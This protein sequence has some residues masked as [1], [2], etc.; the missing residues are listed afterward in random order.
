M[1]I[2]GGAGSIDAEPLKRIRPLVETALR[3]FQGT[4]ISGGTAVGVPGCVGDVA[5]GL[6]AR[7]AKGFQLIGYLPH[8]LPKDAPPDSRYELKECG[9]NGFT[10]EQILQSWRDLTAQGVRPSEVLCLGFGGGPLC[11]VE[12]CV[13]LALGAIVA[14][15]PA[16]EGDAADQLLKDPLWADS[17]NLFAVPPDPTTIRALVVSPTRA[18]GDKTLDAMAKAFHGVYVAGSVNKLPENMKPWA[19]LGETF[20]LANREQA[21]YAVQILEACGFGVRDAESPVVFDSKSFTPEE[22]ERMAEMEHG[23]WN[24]ERLRDGWRPGKRRDDSR[25]IHD[26]LVPW[27]EL[28]DGIKRYDRD[29]V[30]EFPKILAKA[31]LEVSRP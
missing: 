12:F 25:K 2:A 19:N 8:N 20:K 10:P 16:K 4:V 26:C 18:F 9:K 3:P 14:V 15:I 23:R 21:R 6:A 5:S 24:A 29:A 28:P 7:K 27:S 1:I 31:G 22:V 11:W 30:R 17:S 13:A